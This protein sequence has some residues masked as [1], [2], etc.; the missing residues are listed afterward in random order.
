MKIFFAHIMM[1]LTLALAMGCG[2]SRPLDHFVIS[3]NAKPFPTKK[4]SPIYVVLGSEISDELWIAADGPSKLKVRSFR[5]TLQ[6][7]LS[8]TLSQNFRTIYFVDLP[9]TQGLVMQVLQVEARWKAVEGPTPTSQM[10][11]TQAFQSLFHM[12]ASL[13]LNDQVLQKVSFQAEGSVHGEPHA[14]TEAFKS[15]LQGGCEE[16]SDKLFPQDVVSLLK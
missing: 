2:S 4:E 15:G 10:P 14:K 6:D 12:Q 16:L 1:V 7:A 11:K 9:P 13:A 8:A 5:M 3:P